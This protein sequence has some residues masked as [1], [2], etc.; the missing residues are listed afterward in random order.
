MNMTDSISPI[1]TSRIMTSEAGDAGPIAASPEQEPAPLMP[2]PVPASF[3]ADP[4]FAIGALYVQMLQTERSASR[5][6]AR[7]EE[8]R[9]QREEDKKIDDM[10]KAADER[11]T[12]AMISGWTKIASGGLE[13]T[14][15]VMGLCGH[16]LN[17]QDAKA[18]GGAA[19]GT[20]G[21]GELLAANHE[22]DASGA[23]RAAER[24][25]SNVE[26]A[27]RRQQ[28]QEDSASDLRAQLE[29][30]LGYMQ[31]LE[32]ARAQARSAAVLRV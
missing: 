8:A 21:L 4:A 18:F 30:V 23:D 13:A 15:G 27:T 12:H 32:Q 24:H 9:I 14:P 5:R 19:Q 17:D 2:D 25:D 28:L 6:E 22:R 1:T 16:R 10:R 20:A 3:S 29:R 11:F 7:L 26:A 31:E